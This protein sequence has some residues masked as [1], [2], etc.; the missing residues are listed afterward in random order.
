MNRRAENNNNKLTIFIV[1]DSFNWSEGE[2]V[3]RSVHIWLVPFS[4]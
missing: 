4:I 1:F 2:I 3:Y